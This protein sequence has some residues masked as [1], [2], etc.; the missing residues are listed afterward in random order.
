[1]SARTAVHLAGQCPLD[2]ARFTTSGLQTAFRTASTLA[3]V[4]C[5]GYPDQ[6]AELD[7]TAAVS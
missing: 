6:P 7:V 2:L 1:M 4:T 5:L 3:G